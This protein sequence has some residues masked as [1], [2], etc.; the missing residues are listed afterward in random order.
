MSERRHS[1]GVRGWK[2]LVV[3]VRWISEEVVLAGILRET[4]AQQ[5]DIID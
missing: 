1:L 5:W 2:T 4:F 3:R